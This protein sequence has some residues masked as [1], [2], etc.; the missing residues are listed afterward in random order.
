M[1]V[2]VIQRIIQ[3]IDADVEDDF[4]VDVF[5]AVL[6]NQQSAGSQAERDFECVS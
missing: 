3:I 1:I 5:R 2:L 4:L 6:D